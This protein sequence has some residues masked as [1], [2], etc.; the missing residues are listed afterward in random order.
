METR[1]EERRQ[2]HCHGS[3]ALL[4]DPRDHESP[5]HYLLGHALRQPHEKVDDEGDR[6]AVFEAEAD[7]V[8]LS[9]D[10]KDNKYRSHHDKA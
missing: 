7:I 3:V 4:S 2:D 5:E 6:D 10:D 8:N 9:R 1:E